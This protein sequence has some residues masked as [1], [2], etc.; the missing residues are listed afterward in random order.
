MSGMQ[1]TLDPAGAA[2]LQAYLHAHIPLVRHLQVRVDHCDASGVTLSAPL[3]ANTNHEGTAFGGSLE[4][5]AMLA[6][7]GA[8]WLLLEHEARVHI[9]VAESRMRFLRPVTGMLIARGALPEAAILEK[10]RDT[11]QRRNKARIELQAGINQDH[12]AGAQFDGRFV[13]Y[14]DRPHAR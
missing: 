5:L 9:V 12:G 3:A 2:R 6:C 11:L 7:W 13:A 8:V 4:C 14:R 10:F 1:I